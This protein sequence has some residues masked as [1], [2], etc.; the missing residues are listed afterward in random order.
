MPRTLIFAILI[1]LGTA[2][3]SFF[4]SLVFLTTGWKINLTG[5]GRNIDFR[6]VWIQVA[7][8]VS[9]AAGWALL[10]GYRWRRTAQDNE[11]RLAAGFCILFLLFGYTLQTFQAELLASQRRAVPFGN[12]IWIY[13]V[14]GALFLFFLLK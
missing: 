5:G 4:P 14:V 3:W 11:F 8:L 2:L 12:A 9:L 7:L 13:L 10:F 6:N 1:F